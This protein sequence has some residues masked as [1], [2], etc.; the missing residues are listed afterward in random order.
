MRKIKN[1]LFVVLVA[2]AVTAGFIFCGING[3]EQIA[4]TNGPDDAS[5]AVITEAEIV[6]TDPKNC[7]GGPK[8]DRSETSFLGVTLSGGTTYHSEQ[9]SGIYLLESWNL[10]AD[11]DIFFELYEYEVTGGNFLMCMVHD[12]QI[13]A[14]VEPTEDGN[15]SFTMNDVENGLY[16]LY[17]VGESAAFQFVSNDFDEEV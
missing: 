7:V 5:L 17:I 15:V 10:F 14:T 9:F 6:G 8:I 3:M 13:V 4:D 1:G 2:A 16:E 11:S 12:G